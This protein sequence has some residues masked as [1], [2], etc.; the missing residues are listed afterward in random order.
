LAE[1][2]FRPLL[3]DKA[4]ADDGPLRHRILDA[5][6]IHYATP[7]STDVDR[8]RLE[9][10]LLENVSPPGG[11]DRFYRYEGTSAVV[12]VRREGGTAG[13]LA[14]QVLLGSGA[15]I[16]PGTN[17]ATY[18]K[19][20]TVTGRVFQF[21]SGEDDNTFRPRN[22]TVK[23]IKDRL[24]EASESFR[25][26]LRDLFNEGAVLSS[27]W[28]KITDVPG[29]ASEYRGTLPPRDTFASAQSDVY[30]NQQWVPAR[31]TG[32]VVVRYTRATDSYSITVIWQLRAVN[33][34]HSQDVDEDFMSSGNS[35]GPLPDFI[36]GVVDDPFSDKKF[37]F[38]LTKS[39]GGDSISGTV[40]LETPVGLYG[41]TTNPPQLTFV[42][43][44]HEG[45]LLSRE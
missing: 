31:V 7:R 44:L 8:G 30:P 10:V 29:A 33:S 4:D 14:A 5:S 25:L 39:N 15:E 32:E 18:G 40:S 11:F 20:F 2:F 24:D 3:N 45:V 17:A 16:L 37:S 22:V 38:A 28:G 12:T 27:V 36:E 13:F 19:D 21:K 41:Y 43:T 42:T 9:F 6:L 1:N 23:L 26:H 35:S 34:A